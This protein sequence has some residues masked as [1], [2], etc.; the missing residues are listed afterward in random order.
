[1]VWWCHEAPV[2]N[3]ATLSWPEGTTLTVQKGTI[4]LCD[5]EGYAD[6]ILVGMGK[7]KLFDP[8]DK[9]FPLIK[10]WPADNEI[11]LEIRIGK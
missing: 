5:P 9:K 2:Q 8:L 7:L 3:G 4:V 6:E 11:I 1:M 10:V